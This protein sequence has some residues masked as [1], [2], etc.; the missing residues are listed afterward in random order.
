MDLIVTPLPPGF[1]LCLEEGRA[2]PPALRAIIEQIWAAEQA[3][4]GGSLHNGAL[5]ALVRTDADCL[6]VRRTDY[7]HFIAQRRE[8]RLFAELQLRTLAVSGLARSPEG[9]L[10]G[11]RSG[12][13]TQDAG[14]WELVPSGGLSPPAGASDLDG[15]ALVYEQC[16]VELEEETGIPRASV[17]SARAFALVEDPEAHVIDIGVELQLRDFLAA[18]EAST[19]YDQL[20]TVS[21]DALAGF[22]RDREVIPVSRALLEA[23]GLLP[24]G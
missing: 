20:L 1:R 14:R 15:T 23:R 22:V 2:T 6:Y 10:F 21:L 16:F 8:P 12:Q 18:A 9:L 4:R 3:R 17:E 13:V 19:E 7:Q 24:P 5:L 11:R